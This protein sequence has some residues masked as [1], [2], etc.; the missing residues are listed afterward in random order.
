VKTARRLVS[1]GVQMFRDKLNVDTNPK[2]SQI[3]EEKVDEGFA[4]IGAKVMQSSFFRMAQEDL[5]G[6]S[7]SFIPPYFKAQLEFVSFN[8][9]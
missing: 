3:P 6:V 4:Q 1:S 7:Y 9:A 5:L 8:F 2:D